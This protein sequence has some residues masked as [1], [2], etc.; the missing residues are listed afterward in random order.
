MDFMESIHLVLSA[1]IHDGT[2]VINYPWDTWYSSERLHPDNGWYIHAGRRYVDTVHVRTYLM[3]GYMSGFEN[4]ITHGA[5]WYKIIGGRQD[6]VNYFVHAREVT[7]E[8]SNEKYPNNTDDLPFLWNAN[9]ASLLQ[10]IEN[11][12]FGIQGMVSDSLT[13][14][15]VKAM[16]SV[17]DH[18]VDESHVFSDSITGYFARLIEPGSWTLEFT[19]DGYD[20]KT[21]S[22]ILVEWDRATD[23]A[24]QMNPVAEGFHPVT[25][26]EAWPN[27]WIQETQIRF[28]VSI[29]GNRRIMLVSLDGRILMQ[30]ELYCPTTGSCIYELKG[31]DLEPGWYVL[32]LLSPEGI[33]SV[34]ILRSE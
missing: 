27:P 29:P 30:D 16:I 34:K 32:Q 13:G 23:L 5:D 7:L 18:D 17:R 4:G 25:Q 26:P 14:Q 11:S 15:P 12:L 3:P 22:G 20:M 9:Q 21:I 24:V 1:N 33:L 19:A 10:Y 28:H 6:Y 2:E 31:Q 8:I